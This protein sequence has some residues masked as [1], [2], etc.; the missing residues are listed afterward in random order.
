MTENPGAESL[1]R[2]MKR[3]IQYIT[4]F[5]DILVSMHNYDEALC[6]IQNLRNPGVCI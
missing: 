3:N 5:I 2:E 4:Q 1:L 6:E